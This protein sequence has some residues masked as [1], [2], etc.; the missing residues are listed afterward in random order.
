MIHFPYKNIFTGNTV[1]ADDL[2]HKS[3][4]E[5]DLIKDRDAAPNEASV[6]PLRVHSQVPLIAVPEREH[7]LP[8]GV[9]FLRAKMPLNILFL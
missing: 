1:E 9:L 7:I 5:N 6:T 8:M 2:V 4:G 3:C